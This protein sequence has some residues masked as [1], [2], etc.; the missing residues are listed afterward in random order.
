MAERRA[1]RVPV[2]GLGSSLAAWLQRGDFDSVTATIS[3]LAARDADRRWVMTSALIG[4]GLAH[5]TTAAALRPAAPAGRVVLALGGLATLGVAAAPQP[6]GDG[7]S[8]LHTGFATVAFLSLAVWPAFSAL[9]TVA[10]A[11]VAFRRPLV[12]RSPVALGAT[13]VLVGEMVWFFVELRS[14]GQLIGLSERLAAG[15]Q[16]LWPMAA[17]LLAGRNG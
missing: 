1:D 14:D 12:F 3:A 15:S 11:A 2:W 17:V 13:A 8:G 4:V 16:A 9:R 10:R 6:S 5:M 7:S